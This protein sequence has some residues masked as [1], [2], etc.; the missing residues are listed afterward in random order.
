MDLLST[1]LHAPPVREKR[2]ERRRL[3]L[4]LNA[5]VNQKLTLIC[6]PAGY[7]KTTLLSQWINQRSEPVGWL[8]L[9]GSDNDLTQFLRYFLA[10]IQQIDPDVG[11]ADPGDA[12]ASPT[13]VWLGGMDRPDQR[14]GGL[15]ERV[16]HHPG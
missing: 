7:G 4:K 16:H 5:V 14:P 12:A 13:A 8:S 6:A 11:C 10:A 2:V 1:K 9:D 3:L 15:G